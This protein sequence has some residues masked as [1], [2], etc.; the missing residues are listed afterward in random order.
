MFD[1]WLRRADETR[2]VGNAL[3]AFL[4]WGLI[5]RSLLLAALITLLIVEG[6]FLAKWLF[7]WQ[8]APVVYADVKEYTI[9]SYFALGTF[10][11]IGVSLRWVILRRLKAVQAEDDAAAP[12]ASAAEDA[13]KE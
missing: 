9:V 6:N 1:R 11:T 4:W 12:V 5:I 8:I 10:L 3:W 13:A 2:G 7:S